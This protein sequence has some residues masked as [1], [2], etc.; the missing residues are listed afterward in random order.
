[1]TTSVLNEQAADDELLHAGHPDQ[2]GPKQASEDWLMEE[3][4]LEKERNGMTLDKLKSD[5]CQLSLGQL[6]SLVEEQTGCPSQEPHHT[7][8]MILAWAFAH[9]TQDDAK[10]AA[11]LGI[12]IE[13]VFTVTSNAIKSRIW[14]TQLD[15]DDGT[16]FLM[17]INAAMGELEYFPE[18]QTWKMTDK[19]KNFVETKLLTTSAG[20]KLV[21]ELK[22]AE[23][24]AKRREKAES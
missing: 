19:G 22:R 14:E 12:P 5:L 9:D 10:I 23:R 6:A 13:L 3:A 11:G 2:R 16:T 24:V 21:K 7:V 18:S 8:G 15:I 4:I 17:M 1:M 20:A